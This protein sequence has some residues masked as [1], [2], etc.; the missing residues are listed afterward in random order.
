MPLVDDIYRGEAPPVQIAESVAAAS[1][2]SSSSGTFITGRLGALAAVVD[3]AIT[4]WARTRRRGSSASASSQSS[5]STSLR[6]SI[7]TPSRPLQSRWRQRRTNSANTRSINSERQVA[8][9][10]R[11]RQ[12]IRRVDRGF[13]LYIPPSLNPEF[14]ATQLSEDRLQKSISQT[15]SLPIALNRLEAALKKASRAAKKVKGK[16]RQH[17]LGTPPLSLY[18]DYM[19]HEVPTRPASFGDLSTLQSSVPG[20]QKEY[21]Q[22]TRSLS[23]STPGGS[24]DFNRA[25]KAWWLD[26]ASPTWDDLQTIGKLLHIHP[27]TLED[28]LQQDPREKMELF[29]KLGYYFI[30]FR[31][32]QSATVTHSVH[33]RSPSDTDIYQD[34]DDALR[35]ANIYLVVFKEGICTFHFT[36]VSEHIEKVRNRVQLLQDN[37]NMSSDWI[38]H[39][40]LDSV[41]DSFFPFLKEIEQQV[42][43]VESLV[44]SPNDVSSSTN[45]LVDI[46]QVPTDNLCDSNVEKLPDTLTPPLKEVG[47]SAP[48]CD[49]RFSRPRFTQPLFFL[50]LKRSLQNMLKTFATSRDVRVKSTRTTTKSTLLRMAGA[51]RLVTSL[52]RLLATKSEVVSQIRKRFLISGQAASPQG[53]E[54]VEIAIYMGDVQDH[55]L[56]LQQSLHYYERILSESHPSYLTQLRVDVAKTKEHVDVAIL[57]ITVISIGILCLQVPI[58]VAS[59]NI[60]IP[61]NSIDPPGP[62]NYF[63]MVIVLLFMIE[64]VFIV[65]VRRWWVQAKRTRSK[66]S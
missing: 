26:V 4:R 7:Y 9:R 48:S 44:F 22:G 10:L 21:S 2:T 63:A 49:P 5:S 12:K 42:L 64:T 23:E 52:A 32:I 13:T 40:I 6:S 34:N 29:A 30:S 46:K 24:H 41:V 43:A 55:I 65:T 14:T 56:T 59:M 11:V 36:D 31:A 25:P 62:Y 3:N 27:L 66:L 19:S 15:T 1:S 16:Q 58:G 53:N 17:N 38:A 45:T 51:R 61:R 47:E 50:R 28:I 33:Q 20:K 39:G 35:E 54:D 57:T 18:H 8:A 60:R 37:S